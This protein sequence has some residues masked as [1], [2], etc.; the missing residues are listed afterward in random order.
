[1]RRSLLHILPVLLVIGLLLSMFGCA[2]GSGKPSDATTKRPVIHI[3]EK[4]TTTEGEGIT[5]TTLPAEITGTTTVGQQTGGK[6]MIFDKNNRLQPVIL[7]PYGADANESFAAE[8]LQYFVQQATGHK[9]TVTTEGSATFSG[10]QAKNAAFIS[11]GH[12]SLAVNAG[13]VPTYAAVK[14]NGFKLSADSRHLYVCGA[15]SI[16]TRNG[17]YELLHILVGY[18]CY[19]SD[20]IAV[21]APGALSLESVKTAIQSGQTSAGGIYV[22]SFNWREANAGEFFHA[23]TA[24]S[25]AHTT[26]EGTKAIYRFRFNR[27]EEIYFFGHNTHN[28]FTVLDPADY[29]WNDKTGTWSST[30]HRTWY[31]HKSDGTTVTTRYSTTRIEPSQL[32]YSNQQMKETYIQRLLQ[33][34]DAAGTV[35]SCF[36][37]GMEDNVE[38]CQCDACSK[39]TPSLLALRFA[40]DVALAIDD[41]CRKKDRD[42]IKTVL[43][44]YYATETPPAKSAVNFSL[45]K[46]L[47]VMY[48]PIRSNF[49]TPLTSNDTAQIKR[50]TEIVGDGAHAWLY[51]LY[52]KTGLMLFDSF[53]SMRKNYQSLKALGFDGLLD[54]T[55]HYQPVQVAFGAFKTYVMSKLQWDLDFVDP[56]NKTAWDRVTADF[57]DAYYGSASGTMQEIFRKLRGKYQSLGSSI[58]VIWTDMNDSRYWTQAELQE[59]VDLLNKAYGQVSDTQTRERIMRESLGFR[60]ILLSHKTYRPATMTWNGAADTKES[61]RAECKRLGVTYYS[62]GVTVDKW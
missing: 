33:R 48:A 13:A 58:G 21:K 9:P 56:T 8:E 54:Q 16:G 19:A 11:V 5:T 38:W 60:A 40:N 17:V 22:P 50:W 35:P 57:F 29:G 41:W 2:A 15:D 62:E 44:A 53:G 45:S 26:A 32:C 47:S 55:D 25:A 4:T 34:F 28:T 14:E 51:S 18:E 39:S 61:W 36:L 42:P 52:T 37:L 20:E 30:A 59:Y 46:N 12:T 6:T 49:Y 31:S 7:L 10:L 1:M 43:F 24:G 3:G 23:A 27:T